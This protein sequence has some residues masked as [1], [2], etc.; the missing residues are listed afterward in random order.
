MPLSTRL[1][2]RLWLAALASAT[3]VGAASGA[4]L[5]LGPE[6]TTEPPTPQLISLSQTDMTRFDPR[7]AS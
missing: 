6:E 2:A 5:R 7:D 4:A 3:C 1:S